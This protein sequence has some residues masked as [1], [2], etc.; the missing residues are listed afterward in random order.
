MIDELPRNT[1][2]LRPGSVLVCKP[3]RAPFP[4]FEV[5]LILPVVP[6]RYA[7]PYMLADGSVRAAD[8]WWLGDNFTP[9]QQQA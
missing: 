8:F 9:T 4:G 1:D 7:I 3:D 2:M 5:I 6:N